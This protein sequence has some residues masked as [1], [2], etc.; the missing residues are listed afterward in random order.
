MCFLY[1]TSSLK[2]VDVGRGL[3]WA[4][5]WQQ[6]MRTF[7]RFTKTKRREHKHNVKGNHKLQK[8]TK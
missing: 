4:E 5:K 1:M 6:Q 8:E 7:S 2:Q 3:N